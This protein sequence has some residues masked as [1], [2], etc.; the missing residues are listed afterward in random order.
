[1][2][3]GF[4]TH[5]NGKETFFVE[6]IHSGLI[7][8]DLMQSFDI[9][10]NHNFDIDILSSCEPKLHTIRE[11]KTNRWKCGMM[12]DFFINVRKKDM[13]RFAPKVPV[14]S[15]QNIVIFDVKNQEFHSNNGVIYITKRVVYI[16]GKYYGGA[17]IDN[18]IVL[19]NTGCLVQFAKNDGFDTVQN[20]FDYFNSDFIGK[21]IHWTDL[22][23]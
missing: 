20:F 19:N 16:G 13:F 10:Y 1:M 9:G 3:L 14:V 12:I 22:K 7:Q 18:G 17:Y 5:I 15:V 23:Y 6:K 4:S 21:I 2:I 8:N 11:D